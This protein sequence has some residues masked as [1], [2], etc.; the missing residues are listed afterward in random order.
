MCG[1]ELYLKEALV[2]LCLS[3]S[4]L[5][6]EPGSDLSHSKPSELKSRFQEDPPDTVALKCASCLWGLMLDSHFGKLRFSWTLLGK[7]I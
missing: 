4:S 3:T 5:K 7:A 1:N 6:E 2:G